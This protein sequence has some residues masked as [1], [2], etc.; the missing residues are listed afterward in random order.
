MG[1]QTDLQISNKNKTQLFGLIKCSH[2]PYGR[3]YGKIYLEFY[4][5]GDKQISICYPSFASLASQ[6]TSQQICFEKN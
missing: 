4:F 5:I 1:I 3:L 6:D 2:H